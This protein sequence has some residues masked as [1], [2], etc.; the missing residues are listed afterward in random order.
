[1]FESVPL[2]RPEFF[3][4]LGRHL[5]R[6]FLRDYVDQKPAIVPVLCVILYNS[7]CNISL[8][9]HQT[10]MQWHGCQQ[11]EQ[12]LKSS[13]DEEWMTRHRTLKWDKQCFGKSGSTIRNFGSI[14]TTV[15]TSSSWK[16]GEK[17]HVA[18]TGYTKAVPMPAAVWVTISMATFSPKDS[19]GITNTIHCCVRFQLQPI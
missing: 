10:L 13:F 3:I 7:S 9:S 14:L 12:P 6:S 15:I 4:C 8:R 5:G 19:N 11:S 18:L 16:G 2:Q 17:C 1:M